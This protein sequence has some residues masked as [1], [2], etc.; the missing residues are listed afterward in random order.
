MVVE[1]R[2]E[3]IVIVEV[4]VVVVKVRSERKLFL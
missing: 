2:F 4:M 1:V 3:V